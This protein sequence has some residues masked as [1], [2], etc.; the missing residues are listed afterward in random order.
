MLKH[1]LSTARYSLTLCFLAVSAT[2][3]RSASR[4][5]ATICSSE[6]R[7]F[8]MGSSLSKSH[9][10]RNYWHEET[11]QVRPSA[12][13]SLDD[14]G[15]GARWFVLLQRRSSA[16]FAGESDPQHCFLLPNQ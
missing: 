11:G 1:G 5:T 2:D 13:F 14:P 3:V 15:R 7:L 12:V 9:H 8:L 4:S 6:N 10:Y 16:Y